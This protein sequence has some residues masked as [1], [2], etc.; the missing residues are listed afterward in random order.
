[1]TYDPSPRFNRVR[2]CVDVVAHAGM[3][4]SVVAAQVHQ[5]AKVTGIEIV[6]P[7]LLF[8][9]A[10]LEQQ[11]PLISRHRHEVLLAC[12]GDKPSVRLLADKGV[13]EAGLAVVSGELQ[14]C[15]SFEISLCLRYSCGVERVVYGDAGD[16][17]RAALGC[18][19]FARGEDVG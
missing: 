7:P 5:N 18:P 10:R 16:D 9:V 3:R 1:M 8:T 11:P 2:S 17:R 19:S 15:G 14:P 4:Q 13:W 12:V 6:V